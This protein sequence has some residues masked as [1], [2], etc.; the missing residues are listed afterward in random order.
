LANIIP[1]SARLNS[2]LGG[3]KARNPKYP[4]FLDPKLVPS[5]LLNKSET[6]FTQWQV[7]AAFGCARLAFFT[8]MAPYSKLKDSDRISVLRR[9]L[10]L[11]RHRFNKE[12]I[13]YII[14]RELLPLLNRAIDALEQPE[15]H[16]LIQE[17]CALLGEEGES[18]FAA[19]VS[20]FLAPDRNMGTEQKASLLRRKA[21]TEGLAGRRGNVRK[22]LDEA[23]AL[24]GNDLN[25]LANRANTEAFLALS[26]PSVPRLRQAFDQIS[27][28]FVGLRK[29]QERGRIVAITVSNAAAVALHYAIFESI[30]R[31]RNWKAER[32]HA[33]TLADNLFR[34]AGTD[35]WLLRPQYWEDVVRLIRGYGGEPGDLDRIL[36]RQRERLSPKVLVQLREAVTLLRR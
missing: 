19:E 5:A 34:Q 18:G 9:S 11:V 1:L 25:Q 10:Y 35:L 32:D 31:S 23:K 29:K 6:N 7:A 8:G 36:A 2:E 27:S 17:I 28:L 16:L 20:D 33:L 12:M 22:L 26:D 14:Q 24:S 13:E 21:Q 30:F 15:R 3:L 4:L